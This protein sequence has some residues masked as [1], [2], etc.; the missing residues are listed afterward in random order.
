MPFRPGRAAGCVTS[1]WHWA[2]CSPV[3]T[4]DTVGWAVA[5]DAVAAACPQRPLRRVGYA[6]VPSA[7]PVRQ[8]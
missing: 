1:Y 4:W 2:R 6:S 3:Q 8:S 7:R 5:Q